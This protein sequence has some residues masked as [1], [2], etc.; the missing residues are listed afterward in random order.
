M[1]HPFRKLNL[2]RADEI[3]EPFLVIAE[4]LAD[5]VSRIDALRLAFV[6]AGTKQSVERH[7]GLTVH[8]GLG[9]L[10][11]LSHHAF[12]EDGRKSSRKGPGAHSKGR[13]ASTLTQAHPLHMCRGIKH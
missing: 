12:H 3:N 7:S 4:S 6:T 1:G 9:A 8:V 11:S 5:Q 2:G 13:L 10:N